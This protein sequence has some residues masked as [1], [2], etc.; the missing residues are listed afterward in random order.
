MASRKVEPEYVVV[1]HGALEQPGTTT[2]GM[3]LSRP[4][5]RLQQRW[6]HWKERRGSESEDK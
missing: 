5:E 3:L 1:W 4:D 2:K 6:M